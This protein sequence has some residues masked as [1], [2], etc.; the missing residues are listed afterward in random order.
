[1]HIEAVGGMEAAFLLGCLTQ[2]RA[3]QTV[4]SF[5]YVG[6]E[7]HRDRDLPEVA[8]AIQDESSD[9]ARAARDNL[10]DLLGVSRE[11]TM[12]KVGVYGGLSLFYVTGCGFYAYGFNYVGTLSQLKLAIDGEDDDCVTF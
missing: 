7:W 2:A 3:Y 8:K 4:S 12:R 11:D 9:A 6:Q 10:S 5:H 1:M